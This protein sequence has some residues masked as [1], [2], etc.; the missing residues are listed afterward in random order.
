LYLSISYFLDSSI[1]KATYLFSFL[2]NK[3]LHGQQARGRGRKLRERRQLYKS[4]KY[5]SEIKREE[6]Y[7][8]FLLK[9]NLRDTSIEMTR[10]GRVK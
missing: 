5:G 2:P 3:K 4:R 1:S 7:K 10:Q 8:D 9:I 6:M